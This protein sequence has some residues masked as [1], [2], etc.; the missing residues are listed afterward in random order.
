[1]VGQTGDGVM[2]GQSWGEQGCGLA[3]P[4]NPLTQETPSLFTVTIYG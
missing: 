1:M 4:E 2:L 3:P